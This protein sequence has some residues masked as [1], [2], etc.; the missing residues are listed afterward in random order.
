MSTA[1]LEQL[2]QI[3]TTVTLYASDTLKSLGL[4]RGLG[5]A[6]V[7][8]LVLV[9]LLRFK[10]YREIHRRYQ[11]KYEERTLTPEEAQ[12]IMRVSSA[13]DMPLLLNYSLAFALFKTYAVPSISKLLAATKEL[14]SRETVSKRYADTEILIATWVGCPISGYWSEEKSG[15]IDPRAMIALARVNYLHSKYKISNGDYLY[16]LIL[17][18]IEP[19]A[20]ARKYGWRA[21]SPLEE[22]AFCIFWIEIGK[23]MGIHDIPETPEEMRIWAGAYE[24]EYMTPNPI[25]KDVATYTTEELLYLVPKA[26]GIRKWVEGLTI[27]MLDEPIRVAMMQPAQ[28][29]YKHFIVLSTLKSAAFVQRWLMLPRSDSNYGFPIKFELTRNS[30]GSV[31]PRMHPNKYQVRPWYKSM[32]KTVFGKTW[33]MFLVL[34]NWHS[35]V[36]NPLLRPDGYKLDEMGPLAMENKANEEVLKAAAELQGCPITGAFTRR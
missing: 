23:R 21:L 30:D 14:K 18:A 4:V 32:S 29:W 8:Y 12:K 35:H 13:Y 34:V 31:N 15:E 19:A 36:P 20:W 3:L 10:R 26:F 33:D 16:T 17:F 6:L 2:N 11:K 9:R 5:V 1:L 27:C 22:Y 28:P 25:N 24:Q 7:G